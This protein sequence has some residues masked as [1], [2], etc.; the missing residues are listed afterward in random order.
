MEL[1][2]QRV[3]DSDDDEDDGK[4]LR[5]VREGVVF[6]VAAGLVEEFIVVHLG[7]GL[8][9]NGRSVRFTV[10]LKQNDDGDENA[11]DD[12]YDRECHL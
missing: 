9:L 10:L 8:T 2:E 4:D 1:H 7:A 5:D 6:R 12:E 11:E 3:A